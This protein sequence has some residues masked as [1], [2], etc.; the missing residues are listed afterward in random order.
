MAFGTKSGGIGVID[1]FKTGWT[2]TKDSFSVIRHHPKLMVFPLLAGISSFFFFLIFFVPLLIANLVGSGLEYI[3]LFALY[4]VTTF[5]S[6]YFSAALVYGANEAFHGREPGLRDSMKAI[7]GRLG[8][9]VVW[10]AIAATVSII[11][12]SLEE[13]DNPIASILG[14][15]F[16]VGWSIMTFF[17]VPV[18]VFEDVS[19]TSMFK[20]SGS[21]FKDTWGETIGAGFGI[22]LISVLIGIGLIAIAL[23]ISV[24]V[25]AVFPG[26]GIVLGI[27]L[28]GGAFVMAYL[29]NQTVW[30]IAKTALY[31]YAREGEQPEE[32]ENFDFESLGG[33]AEK[34]A[35]PGG[36]STG[37]IKAD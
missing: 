24:P 12:K 8:P 7:N 19:V 3:V 23:V 5:F 21:T 4:F 13:S 34:P 17:I 25:A 14:T 30:G 16:A 2:L 36:Q 20:K 32:F 35:E 22:S 31:V 15:L 11:I 29:L 18:I 28:V 37:G 33:R 26:P 6:T 27:M 9:I 1:R 10:S